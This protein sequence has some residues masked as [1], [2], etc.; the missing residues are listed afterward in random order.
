MGSFFKSSDVIIWSRHCITFV[1]F[2]EGYSLTIALV[3]QECRIC[4]IFDKKYNVFMFY[5]TINW[6]NDLR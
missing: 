3:W 6:F 2:L 5:F 4:V 1:T